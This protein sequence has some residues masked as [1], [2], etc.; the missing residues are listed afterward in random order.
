MTTLTLEEASRQIAA[1][2]EKQRELETL[3]AERIQIPAF[4]SSEVRVGL[5]EGLKA[6]TNIT[7]AKS[8]RFITI[9]SSGG[10]SGGHEIR[11]NGAAQTT[12]GAINFVD[13]DAGAGLVTDDAGNDETEVN[14]SLYRLE[15]QDHTHQSTGAAA[16]Q[17]DHGLALT[18]LTDDD[19][20]QYVLRS[21]L[22]TNEDIFK[23]SAG[24]VARLA[25]P[26]DQKFLGGTGV[27]YAYAIQSGTYASRPAAAT[28]VVGTVYCATD[29]A[30]T[31]YLCTNATTWI[32]L[33]PR[34]VTLRWG[35]DGR[36]RADGSNAQGPIRYPPDLDGITTET[37]ALWKPVRAKAHV[38]TAPA[39]AAINLMLEYGT[40]STPGTDLLSAALSIAAA[41]TEGSSTSFA[42]T[43]IENGAAVELVID[44]VGCTAGSE[45]IDLSVECEFVQIDA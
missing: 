22:T 1:L 15:A 45:G 11:E 3:I 33:N 37:I 38:R 12:R 10:G 19:H 30:N 6:S 9:A 24:A 36:L 7:L 4:D 42:D 43:T 32:V 29:R 14:L 21:I 17:L 31:L 16:G 2:T 18:G 40:T 20:T 34:T 25:A 35:I 41:A 28:A 26:T 8:G 39:G 13:A 23:R 27:A 5:G 44:Q